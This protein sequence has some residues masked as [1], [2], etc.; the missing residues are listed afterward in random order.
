MSRRASSEPPPPPGVADS[1][2][3]LAEGPPR[4]AII[5]TSRSGPSA[6]PSATAT[7]KQ[8]ARRELAGASVARPLVRPAKR[9]AFCSR[10]HF[11]P[12]LYERSWLV[13]P[14]LTFSAAQDLA[15]IAHDRRVAPGA[16]G[17]APPTAPCI[18]PG[19]PRER[20]LLSPSAHPS[21]HRS[22]QRP[23]S[24]AQLPPSWR[25][26]RSHAS[27]LVRNAGQLV[28]KRKLAVDLSARKLLAGGGESLIL[29]APVADQRRER[30]IVTARRG[31]GDARRKRGLAVEKAARLLESANRMT[32]TGRDA[33]GEG[34]AVH[35]VRRRALLGGNLPLHAP[36]A[37]VEFEL[38][39]PI[40]A[41]ARLRVLPLNTGDLRASGGDTRK[42]LPRSSTGVPA[43]VLKHSPRLLDHRL[44]R[45]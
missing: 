37:L 2:L 16:C 36:R 30:R 18:E 32:A 4:P 1:P 20:Q 15:R 5:A 21:L 10:P 27:Q 29:R 7:T 28:A 13:G 25:F 24:L 23:L 11:G 12:R 41:S 9:R 42:T 31:S 19:R 6:P 34:A 40:P 35:H 8:P 33:P 43:V 38:A 26:A 39:A 17:D 3:E 14:Q 45:A 44:S 22:L